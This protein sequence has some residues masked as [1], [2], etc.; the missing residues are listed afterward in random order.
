MFFG[1]NHRHV[2]ACAVQCGEWR[3]AHV[4]CAIHGVASR[5]VRHLLP[6]MSPSTPLNHRHVASLI[7]AVVPGAEGAYAS[8]TCKNVYF[9]FTSHH[10]RE[11][12]RVPLTKLIGHANFVC[13][14]SAYVF[15]GVINV[16]IDVSTHAR[17]MENHLCAAKQ[18][19]IHGIITTGCSLGCI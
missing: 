17:L 9:R 18:Q 8:S 5:R 13:R 10:H 19:N 14:C 16:P 12:W 4:Q 6:Q 7:P 2:G 3:S 1:I 11:L 15:P